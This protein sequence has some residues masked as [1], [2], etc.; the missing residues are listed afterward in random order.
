MGEVWLAQDTRLHRQV[1][2][3]MVRPADDRDAAARD[4]LMREARAAAALNDPHI[5]TVHDVLEDQGEV[6]IVFEYVE[7]ETL[8]ERIAR[9]RIPAPEAVD[10]ATQI[11]K[12]L[13]AA[14][15]HGI[16]HRDLKPSNI[17]IAAGQHVKV[18]DFGIAR[19]IAV[20]TTQDTGGGV[21]SS[22]TLGFVGTASYAAPEQLVS[23]AVDGRADL[24]ALVVVLF[25]MIS[26]ERPFIGH[27]AVQLATAKLGKD[28]PPLSSTGQLVPRALEQ[29]VAALLEREREKRPAS[30]TNVV[31]ALRA[32]Y[33]T[34]DTDSLSRPGSSRPVALLALSILAV[35]LAGIGIWRF[36]G[37]GAARSRASA[38]PVVAV[39]PLVNVSGDPSREFL[40]GGIAESL[41]SSLASLPTV[42][43]LSR[44]SVTE[45]RRRVKDQAALTKDLGATYLVEGSVQE[46]AGQLRITLNLVRSDRTVAWGRSIEAP[47]AEL[48]ELQARLADE[49]SSALDLQ[50]SPADRQRMSSPGTANP[51]ALNAY[52]Q[53]RALLERRDLKG[54]LDAAVASFKRA[55]TLDANF[56]IAY[57]ALGETYWLKYVDTREPEWAQRAREEGFNALRLDADEPVVRY[58]LAVTLSGTGQLKE[59]AD[60]L[61]RVLEIRPNYDDARR[62][63]GQVLLQLG[64]VDEGI[65]QYDK[66]IALRPGFWGYYSAVGVGLVEAGRHRDAIARFKKSIEL[67][68]DNMIGYQQLGAVY[69]N[70]GEL[71]EALRYYGLAI[72]RR[73]NAQSY[74]NIGGIEHLRGNYRAA[75]EAYRHAIELR[76]NSHITYR[77]LGDALMR[78]GQKDEA[79][80]AYQAAIKQAL[81]ELTVNPKD[82]GILSLL[83]LYYQKAGDSKTAASRIDEAMRLGSKGWLITY[84]AAAVHALAGRSGVALLMLKQSLAEGAPWSRIEQDEDFVTLKTQAAFKQLAPEPSVAR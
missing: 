65:E 62:Q 9:G 78:L 27:D 7:G 15:A 52:W 26:G 76:P 74:S 34:A 18:L 11:A 25:E 8:H 4:R 66:A 39:V 35:L 40:A 71:D 32:I 84:R 33:G 53:G 41:I 72:E 60:E 23:S 48:F 14:H 67:Q 83:A 3:K 22:A 36:Q 2:L 16:V 73:P 30:A 80:A 49:L 28:A 24:Y 75:V 19:M 59:A 37:S 57:A 69:S 29:L 17:I 55:I 38:P 20:G 64:K 47:V 21:Q 45:A 54:G 61:R 10:I 68:P 79:T 51:E 42:T 58:T 6:V 81:A 50:L 63:L 56:A 12:A 82:A 31:M 1:A 70:L 46:A 5:A 13:T 43:V 44:A 77:N